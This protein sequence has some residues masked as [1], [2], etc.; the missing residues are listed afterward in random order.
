MR[1]ALL[2]N[3]ISFI[4]NGKINTRSLI[5]KSDKYFI[6][7]AKRL[8]KGR[9]KRKRRNSIYFCHSCVSPFLITGSVL[10]LFIINLR[11]LAGMQQ[12]LKN[13]RDG[14]ESHMRHFLSEFLLVY[15]GF[16]FF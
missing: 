7:I 15:L 12:M 16:F 13:K 8:D 10:L 4:R 1:H 5:P 9:K 14:S 3:T 2:K 6:S 11:M